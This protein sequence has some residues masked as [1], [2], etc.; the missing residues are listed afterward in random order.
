MDEPV[1]QEKRGKSKKACIFFVII[2]ILI[3]GG[4]WYYFYNN[5]EEKIII[6]A[7]GDDTAFEQCSTN[8]P[9][10]CD[11]GQLV[12][13]ASVC[14]CP[15]ILIQ[16]GESCNSQYQTEPK[17][18]TL[19]YILRGEIKQIDYTVYT[20]MVDYIFN[21]PAEIHYEA[22]AQP[23]R[24]DFKLRNINEKEQRELLIPLVVEIQNIANNRE[25]QVRIAVSLVQNVPYQASDRMVV[26]VQN[27]VAYSRYPYEVLYEYQGICGEKSELLAF[28]LQEIGYEVVFFSHGSENHESIG[29]K[30]PEEYSLRETGYCF[31][32][33]TG[34]SIITDSGIEYVDG[35]ILYSDP[36]VI[37][38]S[39]GISFSENLYE[40][41]DAKDLNKIRNGEFILFKNSRFEELKQKYG[42]VEEYYIV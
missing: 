11:Q 35:T 34:P 41:K 15:G 5:G 24:A 14:G 9:Y 10:F 7:C 12:E 17:E 13:K 18:I 42:L 26:L 30:C 27:E 21:L 40:Y 6:T 39:E 22:G 29:V 3:I 28:L 33:T 36:E 32:E 25:E 8:K 38:I 2:F 19:N 31:I 16:E 37:L 23:S 1:P 20:G 4:G